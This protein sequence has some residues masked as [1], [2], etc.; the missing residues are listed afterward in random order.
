MPGCMLSLSW[1]SR[2]PR[3][4]QECFVLLQLGWFCYVA[5]TLVS[6]F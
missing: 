3:P 6:D 4:V 5:V 1:L 2:A